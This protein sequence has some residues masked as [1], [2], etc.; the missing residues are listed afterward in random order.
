MQQLKE[1]LR[2]TDEEPITRKCLHSSHSRT[3][4]LRGPNDGTR[5]ELPAEEYRRLGHDEIGLKVFPTKGRR[6]QIR[7]G[8]RYTGH[9]INHIGQLD[10]I[11]CLVVPRLEV[12]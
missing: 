8:D 9:R 12:K 2:L 4:R 10:R 1:L 6:I 3:L 5:R 11:S 7:E